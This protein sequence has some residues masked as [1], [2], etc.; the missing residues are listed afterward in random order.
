MFESVT[1][2]AGHR[3]LGRDP[4]PMPRSLT[5]ATRGRP[6]RSGRRVA[7]CVAIGAGVIDQQHD[8][9]GVAVSTL[10]L[11]APEQGLDVMDPRF[12]LHPYPHSRDFVRGS[13]I[14][15]PLIARHGQDD[16]QPP[17]PA[18]PESCLGSRKEA[19]LYLVTDPHR[20]GVCP[21]AE[22]QADRTGQA[23]GEDD[24]HVGLDAVLDPAQLGPRDPDRVC[25]CLLT[26][27][28]GE[29]RLSDVCHER[30]QRV[31]HTVR[32]TCDG[33]P[34]GLSCP[35]PAERPLHATYL[36]WPCTVLNAPRI[37]CPSLGCTWWSIRR[38]DGHGRPSAGC[39]TFNRCTAWSDGR[40]PSAQRVPHPAHRPWGAR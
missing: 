12:S 34:R 21:D 18:V 26:Q 36:A 1:S 9:V 24:R 31:S 20:A 11:D 3:R 32:G 2:P 16:L 14:P 30:T 29:S 8:P 23:T 35:Y 33:D 17:S 6:K 22:V 37:R 40:S 27:A 15:G 19:E 4:R 38:S 13:G 39:S 5:A 25:H 10:Q 7:Q 28:G